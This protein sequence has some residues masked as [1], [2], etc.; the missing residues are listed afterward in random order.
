MDTPIPDHAGTFYQSLLETL[1]RSLRP[2]T[3]FEIGTLRG[4]TL[5]LAR[6]ASIAVDPEFCFDQQD[7]IAPIM[8]KPALMLFQM[9]SDA[10]FAQHDPERLLG[11][12]IDMA[13]LDGMHRCEYLLR[14]FINT[15]R[16]CKPNSIIA[17][18]DCLPVEVNMAERSPSAVPADAPHRQG[19]WTGDVW[20]TALL[21]KRVRPELAMTALAAPPTGLILVTNLDPRSQL[22]LNGYATHVRTM[23]DWRLAE[24]GIADLFEELAVEPT[25][26]LATDEQITARFWL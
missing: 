4:D 7:L 16:C 17:L 18:H 26:A 13:F 2:K 14:D 6:C 12:K 19:W 25:S 21:L 1:H 20:R 22:L 15:E 8:A 11:A 5:A 23:L 24:I 3:Y 10:F 9:G